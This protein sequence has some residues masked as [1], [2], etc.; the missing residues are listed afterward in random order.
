MATGRLT[1]HIT[2]RSPG[3]KGRRQ[4]DGPIL[5]SSPQVG[6]CVCARCNHRPSNVNTKCKEWSACCVDR[7]Y[8]ARAE[9]IENNS[10]VGQENIYQRGGC[11]LSRV[12]PRCGRKIFHNAWKDPDRRVG[13]SSV[14]G[15]PRNYTLG[16]GCIYIYV[17]ALRIIN[18]I[19]SRNKGSRELFREVP[20]VA[21]NLD[22]KSH[23]WC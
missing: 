22:G 17:P 11:L 7:G 1:E 9:R 10:T 18:L 2:L 16:P 6:Y 15:C 8:R 4:W 13:R 14:T 19:T 20:M 5:A 21:G 12:A 3:I 23:R